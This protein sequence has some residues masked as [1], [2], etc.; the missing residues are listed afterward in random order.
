[1]T[2]GVLTN[3]VLCWIHF[4]DLAYK[5]FICKSVNVECVFYWIT[6]ISLHTLGFELVYILHFVNYQPDSLTGEHFNYT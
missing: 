3:L 6:A 5:M 1:M 4:C 2:S